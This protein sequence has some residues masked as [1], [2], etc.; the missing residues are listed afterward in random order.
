MCCSCLPQTGLSRPARR[1]TLRGAV[2]SD[3]LRPGLKGPAK[4]S[5]GDV[6]WDM[7]MSGCSNARLLV[8]DEVEG[9]GRR[10]LGGLG[11]NI[12]SQRA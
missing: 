11:S 8:Q 10:R 4:S 5:K 12:L 3:S 1:V 2:S 6:I 9:G 7:D